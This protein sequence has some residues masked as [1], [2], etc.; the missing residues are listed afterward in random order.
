MTNMGWNGKKWEQC[1]SDIG[2]IMG[3]IWGRTCC[4][5]I[6]DAP[7]CLAEYEKHKDLNFCGRKWIGVSCKALTS[8]AEET[9]KMLSEVI[10][11]MSFDDKKRFDTL[12]TELKSE[13]K[14]GIVSSGV[15]YSLRRG[16]A[17]N[18]VAQALNEIMNGISQL[19]TIAGYK[20]SNSKKLLG[21]LKDIYYECLKAGG[22]IHITADEESLKKVMPMLET[23]AK[24]TNITKLLPPVELKLEELLPYVY[25]SDAIIDKKSKQMIFE[26]S[27]TGYAA[28]ISPSSPYL[29]KDAAAEYVFSVWFRMHT[30]WDKIRTTGGA[31]GVSTWAD[32]YTEKFMMYSYRDPTPEKSL[33]VYIDS[34]KNMAKNKISDDDIEKTIVSCYGDAIVPA[35]PK[36]RGDYSFDSMIYCN[37]TKFKKL[38]INNILSVTSD[39]I[40]KAIERLS[41][42]IDEECKTV[43]FCGES[44]YSYGKKIDLPL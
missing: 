44:N 13:K 4:G 14:A 21:I 22:I 3:D 34:L 20:K 37:P 41:K 25:D 32:N 15:E 11:T 27:Q 28:A 33:A 40:D 24:D 17:A 9:L 5:S 26:E 16:A 7:E 38:K 35:S 19:Y 36:K 23:F 10:T 42:W 43:V 6:A 31:Y 29:T 18:G 8:Q 1:T 2:C 12:F 30:L 39:D